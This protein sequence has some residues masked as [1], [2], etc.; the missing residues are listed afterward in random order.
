MTAKN[1]LSRTNR[2]SWMETSGPYIGKIVNHIDSEYMGAI[3]VEILKLNSA[4]NPEGGSGY[5]LPCYY[6]SP[7]YGV[8]PIEGAKPN[9]GFDYT[10]KSY[11]MWAIPPDVGT[12]V[13]VLAMEESYGFG[14]WIGCVQD[15]YMNFMV[16]GRASTTFNDEDSSSAKP[17]GEYNKTLEDA[18]GRDP[19]KY[20]KP[21]DMDT[22]NVL[23]TQGLAGDTNRGTTTSSARR[24]LPSMVFGWSTPGPADRRQGKPVAPY[25]ENFGQSQVPFNR[26]GGSTFVMDDGDPML[27]RKTPASGEKAGPPEYASVEKNESGDVTLP[28]NELTRWRTR[29]GHQILMHNTEDLIYI[30]NAKG[31]TWIELTGNGKIDIFANDSVSIHTSNDLNIKADRDI[32]M[33]AGRNISLKA[34]KDGLITAGEGT[35]IS[36]KT[37]TESAP[38]GINM[39]GPAATPAYEPMRTPQHEPWMSHENLNPSEFSAEKTAADPEAGNTADETGNNFTADYPKVADTFRKGR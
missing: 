10:Q 2:P 5:L 4:G 15:K 36:A 6:V 7:F 11:G 28:H 17:V 18:V 19:T 24:D 30:G 33:S 16:P 14:Y 38:E 23:E 35:H 34:G 25:G 22:C 20:I 1:Q 21:C 32:I 39:N 31:S 37:H 12:K 13:V 3:E 26:L 8:T 29:T 27:L 9:P